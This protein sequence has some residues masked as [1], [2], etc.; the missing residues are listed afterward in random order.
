MIY[1]CLCIILAPLLKPELKNINAVILAMVMALALKSSKFK[2]SIYFSNSLVITITWWSETENLLK[3]KECVAVSSSINAPGSKGPT[4]GSFEVWLSLLINGLN[5]SFVEVGLWASSFNSFML[6][7]IPSS[8]MVCSV[9]F[10][11]FIDGLF[12]N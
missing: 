5:V 9:K 3:I 6:N 10:I 11:G 4:N 7:G 2:G 12:G 8:K 1:I